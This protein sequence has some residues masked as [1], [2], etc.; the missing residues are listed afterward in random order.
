MLVVVDNPEHVSKF[1]GYVKCE[2]SH[3]VNLL[4]G[5]SRK[6]VWAEGYDSPPILTPD[7]V[8]RY[9][10]YIYLNPAK[11]NLVNSIDEYPGVSSWEMFV[12]NK[13]S[14][15]VKA[16]PRCLIA[17]LA[18]PALSIGEQKRLV[19]HYLTQNLLEFEF[20]I[21][22]F[23]WL[24]CFP[25]L[26]ADK[27]A[28]QYKTETISA[29]QASQQQLL[30][31]RAKANKTVIGSTVLRRQSM[32]L[33]YQPKK[34]GRR[35]ICICSDKKLRKSY[36]AFFKKLSY[37]A[38]KVYKCWKLGEFSAKIPP[39]FFAPCAPVIVSAIQLVI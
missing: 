4:L 27:H 1:V 12:L 34:F 13:E 24:E 6:T 32:L 39:G 15:S 28:L 31:E 14:V 3:A 35:M 17:P 26:S 9:I 33:E 8:Q 16:I 21:E 5:R 2:I 11:A 22:P 38:H 20:E 25:A 36:I 30:T 29:L 19:N 10:Q 7:D 23:A 37:K 18:S